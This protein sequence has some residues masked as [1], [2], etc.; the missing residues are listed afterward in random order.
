MPI[1]GE[2]PEGY[3]D[4]GWR[5]NRMDT[6]INCCYKLKHKLRE[7]DN[8]LYLNRCTEVIYI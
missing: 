3:K 5:F 2:P 1:S 6:E 7:F 4:L 8:S